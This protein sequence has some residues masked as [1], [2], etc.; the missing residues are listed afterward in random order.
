[1]DNALSIPTSAP[2]FRPA[3][4]L[5][6]HGRI[7]SVQERGALRRRGNRDDVARLQLVERLHVEVRACVGATHE[8]D[9]HLD[10]PRIATGRWT[11]VCGEIG[12][13]RE[14]HQRGMEDG[15][16][17]ERRRR[18]VGVATMAVGA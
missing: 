10:E 3:L 18:A 14:S 1:M 6:Q 5:P 17:A 2:F 8:R 11:A 12:T 9:L 7:P 13:E 4:F 16:P 15:P